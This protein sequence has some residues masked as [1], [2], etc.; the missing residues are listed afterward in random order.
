MIGF[1]LLPSGHGRPRYFLKHSLRAGAA[2]ATLRIFLAAEPTVPAV[3][4]DNNPFRSS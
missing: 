3:R 2:A 4:I 1:F